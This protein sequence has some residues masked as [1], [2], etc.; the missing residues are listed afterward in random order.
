MNYTTDNAL[1]RTDRAR[2]DAYGRKII[3]AFDLDDTRTTGAYDGVT[4]HRFELAT[5]HDGQRKAYRST[6]WRMTHTTEPSGTQ[7]SLMRSL[8]RGEPSPVAPVIVAAARFSRP[9]MEAA[10]ADALAA[11]FSRPAALA[12]VIAWTRRE[13]EGEDK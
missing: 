4:V 13:T 1:T 5:H 7:S 10:H 3:T 12:D 2:F 8:M 9:K 6:L 11:L